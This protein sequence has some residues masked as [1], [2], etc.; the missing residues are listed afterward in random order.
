MTSALLTLLLL[1]P[2]AGDHVEHQVLGLTFNAPKGAEITRHTLAAGVD[3][4][5]V[6]HGEEVLILSVYHGR[7]IPSVKRALRVHLE[8]LEKKLVKS[9]VP[10]TLTTK[11]SRI[12]LMKRV[13]IG[14]TIQYRKAV[15]GREYSYMAQVVAKR[16]GKRVIVLNWH[17]PV[18]RR[19]QHFSPGL[20]ATMA[21]ARK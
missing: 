16:V 17:S 14:R 9:A 18:R 2:T 11:R 13:A 10:S 12:R 15:A 1:L 4:M 3:G 6:T 21:T 7:R 19:T 20:M 8:E 5:A